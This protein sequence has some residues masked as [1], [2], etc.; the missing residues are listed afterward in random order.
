M[1]I[2]HTVLSFSELWINM[3]QTIQYTDDMNEQMSVI[4]LVRF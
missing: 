3:T 1:S 2:G 4:Q